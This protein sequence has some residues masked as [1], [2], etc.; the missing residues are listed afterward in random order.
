MAILAIHRIEKPG[1]FSYYAIVAIYIG[2]CSYQ[3]L[4][5]K[6]ARNSLSMTMAAMMQYHAFMAFWKCKPVDNHWEKCELKG[7]N[8]HQPIVTQC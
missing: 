5:T 8:G 3:E 6:I 7:I 2:Y 4:I 1:Y